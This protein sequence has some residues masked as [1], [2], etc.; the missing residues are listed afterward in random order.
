MDNNSQQA[1]TEEPQLVQRQAPVTELQQP[2]A[3]T[4]PLPQ[5]QAPEVTVPSSSNTNKPQLRQLPDTELP[6]DL[7]EATA[8]SNRLVTELRLAPRWPEAMDS[9]RP[10]HR[11][12]TDA[13]P[14]P[15][16]ATAPT[17]ARL[18]PATEA[19]QQLQPLKHQCQATAQELRRNPATEPTKAHPAAL[20]AALHQQH[21]LPVAMDNN[22]P[23]VTALRDPVTTRQS[24]Q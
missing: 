16:A 14:L 4:E 21:Q 11:P 7:R 3:A 2:R 22:P 20:T 24:F 12:A 8:N 6:L 15:Q 10:L 18:H 5:H 23:E 19:L 9:R 1:A 17:E 13:R